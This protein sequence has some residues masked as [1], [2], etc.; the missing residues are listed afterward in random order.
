MSDSITDVGQWSGERIREAMRADR[1]HA[2]GNDD[3][4]DHDDEG[5]PRLAWATLVTGRAWK[6]TTV[7]TVNANRTHKMSA[8]SRSKTYS[9]SGQWKP[10]HD[11][12]RADGNGNPHIIKRRIKWERPA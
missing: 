11:R 6:L 9:P 12:R 2:A 4:D 5:D 7:P 10:D 1:L 8:G 3:H